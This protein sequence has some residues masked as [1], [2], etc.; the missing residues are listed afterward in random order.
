[1]LYKAAFFRA[2]TIETAVQE[3]KVTIFPFNPDLFPDH[4]QQTFRIEQQVKISEKQH[5]WK[6]HH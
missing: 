2:A 4:L 3:F 5:S 6:L 1:M